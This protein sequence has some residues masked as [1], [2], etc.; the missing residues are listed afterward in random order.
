MSKNYLLDK[1]INVLMLDN[2]EK[3]LKTTKNY[4]LSNNVNIIITKTL[5]NAKIQLKKN[6]IDCLIIDTSIA[7]NRGSAIIQKLKKDSKLQHIPFV[8]L[9]SRGFSKDR[10]DGYKLGCTAY[11]S[12]PFDPMEL[13]Y[14]IKNLVYKKNLLTQELISN[15]FLLKK[16]RSDIIKKYKYSFRENLDLHLTPKEELILSFILKDKSVKNITEKLKIHTRT[17]EKYISKILDKTDT[18]NNK[19]LK[20]LPW[21]AL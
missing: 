13:Q 9:T 10:L 14:I 3:V 2:E 8:I 12:K 18:K 17:I 4:L 11:V 15:Y 20:T 6:N 19:E 16:L 7:N 1:L 21:N 5:P